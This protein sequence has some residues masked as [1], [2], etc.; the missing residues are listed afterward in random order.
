MRP[1]SRHPRPVVAEIIGDGAIG[2]R[3]DPS[4]GSQGGKYLEKLRPAMKT[5]IA[6]VLSVP[7]SRHLMRRD[8]DVLDAE[9][10]CDPTGVVEIAVG[11]RVGAPGR[12]EDVLPT[13]CR[14]RDGQERGAVDAP[15]EGDDDTS[16]RPEDGE[17]PL[18]FGREI[19][20]HGAHL[21][22][23]SSTQ[24]NAQFLRCTAPHRSGR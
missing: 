21:A 8:D 4:A 23:E 16:L 5:T 10:S 11:D 22:R 13:E 1:S 7:V 20:V 14:D 24:E 3:V 12:G 9:M 19:A 2:D 15:R 17:G 6:G 18:G